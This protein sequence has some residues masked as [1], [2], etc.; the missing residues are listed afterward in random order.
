MLSPLER[1]ERDTITSVLTAHG[2]NKRRTAG[3]LH[4]S[5]TTLY[6]RMRELGIP[7]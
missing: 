3:E 7:G 4:I 1:A 6:K 2:H 5:R